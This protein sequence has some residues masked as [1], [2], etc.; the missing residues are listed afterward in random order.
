MLMIDWLFCHWLAIIGGIGS[1]IFIMSLLIWRN[2][3]IIYRLSNR[4][5]IGNGVL[6]V[7]L[8]LD[9]L[10]LRIVLQDDVG[11]SIILVWIILNLSPNFFHSPLLFSALAAAAHDK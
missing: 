2:I 9:L 5:S 10:I 3:S 11:G 1:C 6:E 8:S 4:L 7:S